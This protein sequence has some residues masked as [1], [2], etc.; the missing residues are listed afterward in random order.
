MKKPVP[1]TVLVFPFL[2]LCKQTK[3]EK[4]LS[5]LLVQDREMNRIAATANGRANART[6]IVPETTRL[7]FATLYSAE[8]K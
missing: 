1:R 2:F 6:P 7:M 4:K 5:S 8:C 3:K